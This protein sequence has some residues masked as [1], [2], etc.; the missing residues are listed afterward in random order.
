MLIWYSD[1]IPMT[2]EGWNWISLKSFS[3]SWGVKLL[4]YLWPVIVLQGG[5]GVQFWG[6]VVFVPMWQLPSVTY[7]SASTLLCRRWP[8]HCGGPQILSFLYMFVPAFRS[9]FEVPAA[10]LVHFKPICN[11]ILQYSL[12]PSNSELCLKWERNFFPE[13]TWQA[14]RT[15]YYF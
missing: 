11:C 15:Y 14:F 10:A 12:L 13:W 4:L 1:R 6:I 8:P 2:G 9:S 5:G 7:F 3:N